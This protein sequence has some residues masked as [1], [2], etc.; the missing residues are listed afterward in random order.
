MM[1]R[2]LFLIASILCLGWLSMGYRTSPTLH[3]MSN[4]VI[5]TDVMYLPGKVADS[6]NPKSEFSELFENNENGIRLNPRAFTFVQDYMEKNSE[7]LL[8]MKGWA[9][10]YFNMIDGVFRKYGLPTELKY[11]AVIESEL[12]S[13]AVSRVGAVGP[14]QFMPET[15]RL[16]GLKVTKTK[17][18][19]KDFT[20]ST[21]A[22]AKYL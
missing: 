11:L 6:S 10:P 5:L 7:D 8:K 20:K 21:H 15:A 18:E 22:A 3:R 2:K 1:K 16:V 19:R 13:T 9:T 17:D 14:W 4:R 12:K